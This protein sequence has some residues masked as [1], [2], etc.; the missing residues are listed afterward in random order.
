MSVW[1]RL[2]RVGKRAAKFQF[3]ASYQELVLECTKKWQPNKI[4]VAWTRRSRRKSSEIRKWEPT[5]KNP[6][7]GVVVWPV[8]EN[9]EITVTLFSDPRTN[10]FEDKEWL[11]FVED[12]GSNGKRRQLASC[13]VNMKKYAS[14]VPSQNDVQLVFKPL[15]KKVVSCKLQLTISCVFLRE[16]KAT[17]EDMQSIASLM[18]INRD[19]DIGNLDDFDESAEQ[20][21]ISDVKDADTSAKIS[22]IASKFGMWA[23]GEG[24]VDEM[25]SSII[26]EEEE[27]AGEETP[28]VKQ[29]VDVLPLQPMPQTHKPVSSRE[30]QPIFDL[31]RPRLSSEHE[32]DNVSPESD[33][34]KES[35][36]ITQM[37]ESC[38]KRS[39]D[40]EKKSAD[41]SNSPDSKTSSILGSPHKRSDPALLQPLNLVTDVGEEPVPCDTVATPGID[42]LEWCKEVTKGYPGVKV[43]N[44]TTSWRNGLAFCAIVHRFRSDLIDFENLSPHDIKGNNRKAFDAASSL[45]IPRVIE[46]SDMVILAVPDKLMVM[47][48]LYQLRT[49]F[50]GRDL[51][52]R[53]IGRKATESQ[54]AVGRSDEH[55]ESSSSRASPVKEH[56]KPDRH[57]SS[58]SRSRSPPTLAASKT[59]QETSVPGGGGGRGAMAPLVGHERKIPVPSSLVVQKPG[60]PGDVS[61]KKLM[62]RKQLMNPFDS[63]SEPEEHA[64]RSRDKVLHQK[65]RPFEGQL[66]PSAEV[67]ETDLMSSSPIKETDI[68]SPYNQDTTISCVEDMASVSP[69]KEET[70]IVSP[71]KETDIASPQ[72]EE[73]AI[74]SPYKEVTA[75][76]SPYKVETAIVSP[77]KEET[78]IV[79]PYVEETAIVSP[80][81]EEGEADS[82]LAGK[83]EWNND[84]IDAMDSK[85]SSNRQDE[86]KER[87][88]LL[89][90]QARRDAAKQSE[91]P[92]SPV[93]QPCT[94]GI[95]VEDVERQKQLRERARKLIAEA[96]HGLQGSNTSSP[97]D[98]SLTA[99]ALSTKHVNSTGPK[100]KFYQFRKAGSGGQSSPLSPIQKLSLKPVGV[101]QPSEQDLNSPT[102][103]SPKTN[104][105]PNKRQAISPTKTY[106]VIKLKRP[107]SLSDG[108][109][110]SFKQS[111]LQSPE[112]FVDTSQYVSGE[113]LALEREMAQIDERATLV[114]KKL[115]AVMGKNKDAEEKYLQEWFLLVNKKNALIRRQ[116]QLD[117]LEKEHD[118]ETRYELLNRDLRQMM[119]IE[120]WEKTE[121]QKKREELLLDEL[122]KL[123]NERDK[124]VQTLDSQERAIESDEVVENEL[125]RR[126]VQIKE[127]KNC[128]I[129]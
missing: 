23:A 126:G 52:V 116:D 11:F 109:V 51:E 94:E 2:Q 41:K 122:V 114:E 33:S 88:K 18:S 103:I 84:V 105:Q 62:T 73:T 113:M 56:A 6:Y 19:N 12:V 47:T 90:E 93:D 57:S 123:V 70:A 39:D 21:D 66:S 34:N 110:A 29:E 69:Y 108:P 44:M 124:L 107:T 5:I 83:S 64:H 112:D 40:K 119:S 106:N 80:Y 65:H 27:S 85:E 54:Y 58:K 77:F 49:H 37:F 50:T 38:K 20:A 15:S 9:M 92:E 48:Y 86:L 43:T 74:V 67:R 14:M 120:E 76:V 4:S 78:D 7:R 75:M 25:S 35:E 87:A 59:K 1:K 68:I 24:T 95:S 42:L 72:M 26:N 128:S 10:D 16:G 101:L 82:G 79:S 100:L 89:L 91:Q 102:K 17:D 30:A 46:P 121:D 99:N 45:G 22:E 71:F 13:C 32:P 97:N 53:Q 115:R 3:T 61:K 96:R 63:D 28:E 111:E 104:V 127:E 31:C 129:Q 118:L 98:E 125:N 8:P 36:D 60:T 81:M 117:V 55:S